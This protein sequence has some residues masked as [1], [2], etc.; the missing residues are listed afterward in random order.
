MVLFDMYLEKSTGKIY[1][2]RRREEDGADTAVATDVANWGFIWRE[3]ATIA[4]QKTA[5]ETI[6]PNTSKVID[7]PAESKKLI[8]SYEDNLWD[9]DQ[10]PITVYKKITKT[11]QTPKEKSIALSQ[12]IKHYSVNLREGEVHSLQV[13][14]FNINGVKKHKG[15]TTYLEAVAETAA[16]ETAAAAA[17]AEAAAE[18]AE[19]LELELFYHKGDSFHYDLLKKAAAAAAAAAAHEL[20]SKK[21]SNRKFLAMTKY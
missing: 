18:A 9:D 11:G 3:T 8:L 20:T 2:A 21:T 13:F 19:G 7:P 14:N 12:I 1:T 10:D 17:E 5:K 4:L 16:A 6:N 15:C